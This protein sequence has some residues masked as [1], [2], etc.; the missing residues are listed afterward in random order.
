MANDINSVTMT[1]RVVR[2]VELRYTAGGTACT[3][4]S[5]AVN[6]RRKTNGE[7]REEPNFFDFTLWGKTAEAISTYLSKGTQIAIQGELQQSRWED[8]EGNNRTSISINVRNVKLIGS[9]SQKHENGKHNEQHDPRYPDQSR[10][11]QP[12]QPHVAQGEF[13]DD[14][15]PF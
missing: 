6:Q 12:Q 2:D 10:R 7:W 1:R 13:F 15:I 14:D 4:G 9:P 11:P 8:R 5:I 3:K